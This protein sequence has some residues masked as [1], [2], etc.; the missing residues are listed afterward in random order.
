MLLS[1]VSLYEQLISFLFSISPEPTNFINRLATM[2]LN[3]GRLKL[4]DERRLRKNYEDLV[5]EI[6]GKY[7][8]TTLFSKNIFTLDDKEEV[9]SLPTR[10][11]Q[12]QKMLDKL[13]HCG[14]G[15]AFSVFMKILEKEY[16]HMADKLKNTVI[17]DT[18]G[19]STRPECE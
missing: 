17:E 14:P 18:P 15:D 11:K 2:A 8:L 12:T 9:E 7:F 3:R 13:F 1:F 6:D 4:E 10:K 16:P 5:D 19:H